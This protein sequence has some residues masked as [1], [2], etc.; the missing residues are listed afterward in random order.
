MS[1]TI[2]AIMRHMV[3]SSA[4]SGSTN[5]SAQTT[6]AAPLRRKRERKLGVVFAPRP[7]SAVIT[8]IH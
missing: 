5:A 6:T 3:R 4:R 1:R 2:K 8:P 7:L